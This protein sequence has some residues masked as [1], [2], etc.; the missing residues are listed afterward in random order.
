[1]FLSPSASDIAAHAPSFLNALDPS[2]SVFDWRLVHDT[3]KVTNPV[4]ELRGRLVD[5]Q[6]RLQELNGR[7]YAVYIL[8]HESDGNGRSLTKEHIIRARAWFCDIDH[9]NTKPLE[10]VSTW[11]Y[12]DHLPIPSMVVSSA[13]GPHLYWLPSTAPHLAQ[14]VLVNRAIARLCDGDRNVGKVTQVLRVPGFYHHKKGVSTLVTLVKPDDGTR[15]TPEAMRAAFPFDPQDAYDPQDARKSSG[16]FAVTDITDEERTWAKGE[17]QALLEKRPAD[18]NDGT[19]EAWTFKTALLVADYLTTEED[20]MSVLRPWNARSTPPLSDEELKVRWDHAVT[21]RKS[22]L[23]ERIGERRF[24][25]GLWSFVEDKP[26][27]PGPTEP[28]TPDAPPTEHG[29][30]YVD[31]SNINPDQTARDIVQAMVRTCDALYTADGQLL[32][33]MPQRK[34]PAGSR[35]VASPSL[36]PLNG[37]SLF[38][39]VSR[40]VLF[41]KLN[42]EGEWKPTGVPREAI[43]VVL[44]SPA[45]WAE[46]PHISRVVT[47][48]YLKMDG[49][50]A[51]PGYDPAMAMAYLPDANYVPVDGQV[52]QED[53]RRAAQRLLDLVE[54]FPFAGEEHKASWL[55]LVLTFFAH[56]AHNGKEP[57]FLI[58][59]NTP[60]SGKGL[61]AE[62]ALQLAYGTPPAAT[63]I[64]WDADEEME[65]RIVGLLMEKRPV[66]FADNISGVLGGE[67]FDL[68]ITGQVYSGRVLG[69]NNMKQLPIDLTWVGTGNNAILK[70]DA[71]RR[72]SYCRLES[73]LEHP[74]LRTGF[75]FPDL[76][77]HVRERR[78]DY[79]RDA[80]TILRGYHQ[81]GRPPQAMEPWGSFEK[82]SQLVRGAVMWVGLPDPKTANRAMPA[83]ADTTRDAAVEVLKA[84]E[85]YLVAVKQQVL[86]SKDLQGI[87]VTPALHPH[88]KDLLAALQG[89]CGD[90]RPAVRTIS[91]K[92]MRLRN[93]V[94][95]GKRLVS[96]RQ[97]NTLAWAVESVT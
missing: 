86:R 40:H 81:A 35:L 74:E 30:V 17:V 8:V 45:L 84:M 46:I 60:G 55:A 77:G 82:W 64:Q 87:L 54:D 13:R 44:R 42:E 3:D 23:G 90:E 58:E 72:V 71:A 80:L 5:L 7:G 12:P 67:L 79:V 83:S 56:Q 78:V 61:L 29:K 50:I 31:V 38:Y 33:L 9:P 70:G 75:K 73:P 62:V 85:G 41:R 1:M 16:K 26:S 51:T 59:A 94:L 49:T 43:N 18:L 22:R 11:Q 4:V 27:A 91:N 48:P 92:L 14:C 63:Q 25:L 10:W 6:P 19:Q 76:M 89:L 65:K 28:A 66:V 15:F 34:V 93:R 21:Y 95:D 52:S 69:S 20:A 96:R 88:A 97:D 68:L 32:E 39:L 36:V 53:A 24:E 47:S 37:D 2:T 57:F